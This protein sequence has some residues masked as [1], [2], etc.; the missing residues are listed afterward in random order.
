MRALLAL[1]I[2]MG[3]LIVVGVGIVAATIVHRMGGATPHAFAG[4]TLDE[5][6]GTHIAAVTSYGDR[7][8][9]TLQGGGPDRIT[10]FDP[11]AGR[12][13]GHISLAH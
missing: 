13:L 5:P 3:V 9:I 7:L 12:T 10:L 2:V 4:G 1:V 6:S 11:I 8:A